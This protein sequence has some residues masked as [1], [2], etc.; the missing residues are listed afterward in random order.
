M[1]K[2]ILNLLKKKNKHKITCLT[3]YTSSIAKIVDNHCDIILV[4]DSVGTA[5]YGMKSTKEVSVDTMIMHSKSVVSV[6]KKSL[7]VVD[8]P[9]KTYD[10]KIQALENARK[11]LNKT[12]CDAVKLEGGKEKAKIIKHLVKNKVSVMGHI[13]L[14]PQSTKSYKARGKSETERKK[15]LEDAISLQ[16]AGVFAIVMECIVESIA[17]KITSKLKIPT[18]GIGASKYCDGQILVIDDLIGLSNFNSK[19]V[20]KYANVRKIIENSVKKFCIDVKQSR[21]PGIKNTYKNKS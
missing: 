21:F 7:V 3:S 15:L 18:I 2:K 14:L 6:S 10:D 19:F 1:K 16:E 20:K 12:S 11:I 8:M 9:Y 5:L 17:K 13:G 4:G